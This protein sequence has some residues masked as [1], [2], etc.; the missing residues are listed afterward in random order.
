MNFTPF[1]DYIFLCHKELLFLHLEKCF[2]SVYMKYYVK[3]LFAAFA[4]VVALSGVAC[5]DADVKE[6]PNPETS[7]ELIEVRVA[8]TT[9]NTRTQLMEDGF[10]TRWS[11]DDQIALWAES[12]DEFTLKAQAFK[13]FHYGMEY[14]SAYFTSLV[15]AMPS[16]SYT[17]YGCY[18]NPESVEGSVANF[19][20]PAV[21]SGE[22]SLDA[23]IM[24][25]NPIVGGSL[26]DK[27][28]G[29]LQM[30]FKHKLHILKITIPEQKN[31]MGEGI[32]RL[33]ITFPVPVVGGVS[34]DVKNPD[35]DVVVT[36]GSN[37]LVIDP[38][39]L[40][41]EGDTLY[42]VIAP[43]DTMGEVI[44]FRGYTA[45]QETELIYTSG[46]IF[47]AE[48]L[49]PIKLTIPELR[50]ITYVTFTIAEN[51]LGETPNSFTVRAPSGVTF[52]D[53][54]S[55]QAFAVN[56]S[57]SYTF[58]YEGECIELSGTTFTVEY[59]S[60]NA[61]V[62]GTTKV[63]ISPY[64]KNYVS[65][66]VPYLF[67]ENFDYILAESEYYGNNDYNSGSER[68]QDGRSLDGAMPTN[69]WNAARYWLKPGACRINARYQVAVFAFTSSHYG[70]LDTPCLTNLKSGAN[71]KLKVWFDAGNYTHS[72]SNSDAKSGTYAF[73]SL[74]THTNS[75]N[76]INGVGIGSAQSGAV[77]DFGTTYYT[78]GA[79]GNDFG[80]NA[81]SGTTFPTHQADVASATSQTRLCFYPTTTFSTMGVGANAEFHV[82]I[83][84]I[85]V[86][87]AQ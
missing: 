2:L 37:V 73:I 49:T 27:E 55:A 48:H 30:S 61:K 25:A 14:P 24:V 59:D 65:L 77:T 79:M 87:I 5:S 66:T 31:L 13:L 10:S 44:S 38:E 60:P 21:Q 8:T 53:G 50:K 11:N 51:N 75:S 82:Y 40:I 47:E 46:K 41:Q 34:L 70:R 4:I 18:P 3:H 86:S 29:E 54:S 9:D 1:V 63:A 32:D 28:A 68:N 42:A 56:D 35:A 74:A 85:R 69:G 76:P 20:I 72:S 22:N 7:D 17:Y 71:V 81:F 62:S 12:G 6:Y 67:S 84:N 19:T 64:R 45:E 26:T 83:D 52:P 78:S 15:S 57:N 23:A 33:E 58:V 39:E 16:G 80:D 36:N 43:V